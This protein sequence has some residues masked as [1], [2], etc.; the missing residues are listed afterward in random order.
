MSWKQQAE[1]IEE[2]QFQNEAVEIEEQS[3]PTFRELAQEINETGAPLRQASQNV[4]KKKLKE[5]YTGHLARG[6]LNTAI[7]LANI[8]ADFIRTMEES[9]Y[10]PSPPSFLGG[11]T[12]MTPIN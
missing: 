12:G 1:L 6:W 10:A 9:M 11:A 7:G 4:Q 2:P 5:S 8:P 3:I